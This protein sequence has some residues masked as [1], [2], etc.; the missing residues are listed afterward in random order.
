MS[1]KFI[2]AVIATIIFIGGV[3]GYN[4]Y[5][6]IFGKAIT[7][8]TVLYVNSSDSLIDVKDKLAE[9]SKNPN[10][11]LLVAAKKNFSKPKPGRYVLK[12]GMSNNDLV[13]MLEVEIKLP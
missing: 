1:K 2:Y 5:Q 9:F 6:K 13:N 3:I 12:E 4:Y 10:T 11:F 8:E 7:K